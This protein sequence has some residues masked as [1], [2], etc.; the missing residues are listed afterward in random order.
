MEKV[1]TGRPFACN[2]QAYEKTPTSEPQGTKRPQ[3]R[4]NPT[5]EM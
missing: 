3:G 1:P 5:G 2:L 4:T